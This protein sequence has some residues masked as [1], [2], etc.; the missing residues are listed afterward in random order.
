M[1][2]LVRCYILKSEGMIK[3]AKEKVLRAMLLKR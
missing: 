1:Y 2:E 3:L